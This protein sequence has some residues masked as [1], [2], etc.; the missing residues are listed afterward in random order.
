MKFMRYISSLSAEEVARTGWEGFKQHR[1]VVVPGTL[2]KATA[3]AGRYA[4]RWLMLPVMRFLQMPP[5]V[6]GNR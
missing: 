2:N 1:R 3:Y 4:P 6:R 5:Q